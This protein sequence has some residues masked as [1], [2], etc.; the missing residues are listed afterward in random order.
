MCA[1]I[2]DSYRIAY[3]NSTLVLN[4]IKLISYEVRIF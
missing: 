1:F 4:K 2:F 3:G